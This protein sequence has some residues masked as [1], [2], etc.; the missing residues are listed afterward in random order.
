MSCSAYEKA[1][2]GVDIAIH[3]RRFDDELDGLTPPINLSHNSIGA[4]GKR[5]LYSSGAG[6]LTIRLMAKLD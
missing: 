1:G 2:T 5:S 4:T 6:L 3:C